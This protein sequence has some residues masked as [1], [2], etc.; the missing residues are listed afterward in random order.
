MID[1]SR[2]IEDCGSKK[3]EDIIESDQVDSEGSDAYDDPQFI[4]DSLNASL[5][6]IKTA[7][8]FFTA[9]SC[10]ELP[11]PGLSIEGIGPI[12]LPLTENTARTIVDVC[13]QAPYGKG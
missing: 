2:R 8:S 4:K 1:L 12:G 3:D 6:E 5:S 7:G 13:H 10:S 11:L 9:G